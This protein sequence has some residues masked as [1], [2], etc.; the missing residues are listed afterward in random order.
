M[1]VKEP[2]T[3]QRP[4]RPEEATFWAEQPSGRAVPPG[5]A[6]LYPGDPFKTR[7]AK[8]LASERGVKV[9][10][11]TAKRG[12]FTSVTA[13]LVPSDILA[14]VAAEAVTTEAE[15]AKKRVA[16]QKARAK[17]HVRELA[18]AADT[19]R[20]LYPAIPAGE[21]ERVAVHA[22]EVGT[23][24]VGRARN[25]SAERKA[26]LAV[27]SHVRHE[28]TDYGDLLFDGWS[29]RD[30]RERVANQIDAVLARWAGGTE[31]ASEA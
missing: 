4:G 1:T 10:A 6:F 19:I 7:R 31:P 20:R 30:A 5:Y 22:Y 21:A 18:Q 29:K 25:L 26:V 3:P 15:R 11:R 14:A 23:G 8:Q 13:Y 2:T 27:V 16:S 12:R 17:A 9:F 24:R 28:H